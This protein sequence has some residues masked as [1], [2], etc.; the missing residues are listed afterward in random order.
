MARQALEVLKE[1]EA[2]LEG[3]FLLTTGRHSDKYMQ[4]AKIFQD[5]RYSVPL[6]GELSLRPG[7]PS[8]LQ[9]PPP[10]RGDAGYLRDRPGQTPPGRSQPGGD[11]VYHIPL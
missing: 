6:C 3:H 8:G 5:A 11:R 10:G 9:Y 7:G 1:C 4:C 2:F